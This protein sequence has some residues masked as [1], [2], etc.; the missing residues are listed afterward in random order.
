MTKNT[1]LQSAY[2]LFAKNGFNATS[3]NDIVK[4]SQLT[5]GA[6]YYHFSSKDELFV[7]TAIYIHQK[8]NLDEL[9][10]FEKTT[11]KTYKKQILNMGLKI[12]QLYE[13]DPMFSDFIWE[14]YMLARKNKHIR[15]LIMQK[16]EL[17]KP[18]YDRAIQK[19]IELGVFEK[20]SDVAYI[21]FK[22]KTTL[23]AIGLHMNL[24]INCFDVKNMWKKTIKEIF[25]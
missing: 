17:K 20:K 2:V 24:N 11:K 3:M 25:V 9:L 7:E 18:L 16:A 10:D 4:H 6:I 23:D 5:K 8:Y 1:I 12:I 13:T 15:L 19:G 22:L 21:Q 14:S